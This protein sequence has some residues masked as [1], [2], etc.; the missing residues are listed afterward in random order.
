MLDTHELIRAAEALK[1][2]GIPITTG[3]VARLIRQGRLEAKR[4]G[5]LWY[6]T[7]EAIQ[8][9]MLVVAEGQP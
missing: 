6:T 4:I 9:A 2:S 8:A 3:H 5:G 1:R 7:P